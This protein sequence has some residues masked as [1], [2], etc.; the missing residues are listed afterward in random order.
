[1]CGTHTPS[2]IEIANAGKILEMLLKTDDISFEQHPDRQDIFIV[3]EPET[4][5]ELVVDV[6]ESTICFLM[7]ICPVPAEDHQ[8]LALYEK[9]L[10]INNISVHGAFSTSDGKV[11]F[12]DNLEIE[13]I[14]QNELDA[15]V[16]LMLVTVA[17]NIEA[18]SEIVAVK[19]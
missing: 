16:Q 18:I 10:E 11:I 3:K 2:E 15:S 6:E 1:M 7:D 14:D 5:L 17:Q 9:L 19:A 8:K 13:N 12:K 4:G